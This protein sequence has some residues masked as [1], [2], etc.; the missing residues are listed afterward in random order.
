MIPQFYLKQWADPQGDGYVWEFR[1]RYN[2]IEGRKRFP[3][4]TGYEHGLYTF[5][6]LPP[7][8]ATYL[9]TEFFAGSDDAAYAV[10]REMLEDRVEFNAK[11]RTA[12]SRFIMTL[13]HRNPEAV[14]RIRSRVIAGY[15]TQIET[16]RESYQ[17]MRHANDPET[18]EEFV[19]TITE[20]DY[21]QVTLRVLH[22]VMDSENVGHVL[23]NMQWAVL[24]INRSEY[25]LLT[26]DRPLVVT[27]GLIKAK[28][29]LVMPI[30]P[31]RVL[32]GRRYP[33]H[34][35]RIVSGLP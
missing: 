32:H 23:N 31:N 12:W 19:S 21:Q 18:F 15:P 33:K 27:N 10:L 16:L 9:E 17:T 25:P 30:S 29:H 2:G 22:K 11:K 20:A 1:C 14:R 3:D 4:G 34:N 8:A 13:L 28:A 24:R 26:S 6:D 5:S 35:A 7:I